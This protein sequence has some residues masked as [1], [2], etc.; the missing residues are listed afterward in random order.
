MAE[1]LS[2]EGQI[3]STNW[4]NMNYGLYDAAA[5]TISAIG[6]SD[7]LM[8]FNGKVIGEIQSLTYSVKR[9]I[10]PIYVMGHADPI[11]WGR[12]KRGIAGSF[13]LQTFDRDPLMNTLVGN[14]LEQ[15]N[16]AAIVGTLP[17]FA[18]TINQLSGTNND[19]IRISDLVKRIADIDTFTDT[20]NAGLDDT[21]PLTNTAGF[22]S[23]Y[24]MYRAVNW[25]GPGGILYGDQIPPFNIVVS[26]VNELGQNSRMEFI[27]VQV[28]SEGAGM[29]VDDMSIS[30]AYSFVAIQ[31]IPQ[32]PGIGLA[33]G[34]EAPPAIQADTTSNF[35]T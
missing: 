23:L 3:D 6:G 1:K 29:S 20:L 16:R 28:V 9:E 26:M 30:K 13:V 5:R 25:W 33:E 22:N 35:G 21:T 2:R 4:T 7:I 32:R 10:A 31:V 18:Y 11:A 14:Y 15:S 8:T 24:N 34:L 27:G 12:G 17:Q 19:G